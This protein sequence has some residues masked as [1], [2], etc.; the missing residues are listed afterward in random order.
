MRGLIFKSIAALA[1]IILYSVLY[2]VAVA[3]S[4]VEVV[5]LFKNRAV[6]KTTNG[7][8]MLSIGQTSQAGVTLLA[9]DQNGATVRYSDETIDLKLS[10][11]VGARFVESPTKA[12][13]ISQDQLGQYRV[14]GAINGQYVN[15]LVDTGASI[16]A[17]SAR[18]A[19]KMGLP[20]E[21]GRRGMVQTA[22]GHTDAFFLKLDKVT[23]G[24]IDVHGV[25]ATVIDGDFPVDVLL[26]MSFLNNIRLE[27]ERGVLTLSSTF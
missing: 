1:A 2:G 21:T 7:Q 8:E 9:A 18:E 24:A 13:R 27:D 14:R 26:G 6:I 5:A 25:E 3:N 12:V 4:P 19:R 11:R 17:I 16:V 10:S 23:V 15:F 20:Y 22:Q